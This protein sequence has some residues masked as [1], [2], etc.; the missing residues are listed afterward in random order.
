MPRRPTTRGP[1]GRRS[2]PPSPTYAH[3]AGAAT[4]PTASE[5]R[6]AQSR[7]A[8]IVEREA[9]YLLAELRRIALV[10]GTCVGMLVMLVVVDRLQ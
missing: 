8:R 5:R 9:P 7:P 10:T 2:L 3:A 4:A 6:P 1:L